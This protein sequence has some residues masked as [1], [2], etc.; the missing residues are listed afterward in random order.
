MGHTT[1]NNLLNSFQSKLEPFSVAKLLQVGVDGPSVNWSFYGKLNNERNELILPELLH[2]GSCGLHVLHRF[3]KTGSN[4]AEWKLAKI[5][6]GLYKLFDESPTRRA[7]Y[8]ELTGTNLASKD[9]YMIFFLS[10]FHLLRK[11][12]I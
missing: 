5:L 10:T 8:I 3:Y 9:S 11:R 7:D 4:A 6:K 2:T 12:Q 1:A